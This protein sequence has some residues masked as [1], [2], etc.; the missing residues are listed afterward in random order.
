MLI[1]DLPRWFERAPGGMAPLEILVRGIIEDD[2]RNAFVVAADR[3]VWRFVARASGLR[4]AMGTVVDL[5]PLPVEALEQA[6]TRSCEIK[7]DIV[8]RDETEQGI[9]ALLN[10]GHTFG[11]AIE[12]VHGYGRWLHGEAVAAGMMMAAQFS[13]R[14][15]SLPASV[16]PRIEALLEAAGLPEPYLVNGA[17]QK[18]IEGVSMEYTWDDPDA[19]STHH[20]QYFEIFGNRGIYQDGWTAVTHHSTP[21]LSREWPSFDEDDWELYDTNTDWTQSKDLARENPEKLAELKRLFSKSAH[22]AM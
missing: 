19:E 1:A 11:H 3:A 20:T 17:A 22:P 8:A 21:W 18:P 2:G 7:A 15:G 12:A 10:L 6:I 4:D 9:R 13:A 14:V 16:V 5:G